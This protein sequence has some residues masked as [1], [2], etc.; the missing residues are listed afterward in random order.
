[1]EGSGGGEIVIVCGSIDIGDIVGRVV[2]VV[3]DVS[4][5]DIILLREPL[6]VIVFEIR[7]DVVERGK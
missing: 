2:E 1:M 5:G 4:E 7:H 6:R 3:V